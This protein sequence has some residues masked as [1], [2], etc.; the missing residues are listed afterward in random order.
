M[1]LIIATDLGLLRVYRVTRGGPGR[2]PH[3]ALLE[4]YRPAE[5]HQKLSEQVTDQAGRF[6]GGI[7][8]GGAVLSAGERHDLQQEQG[9]RLLREMAR[10]IDAHLDDSEVERACLAVSAPIR[11][12]LLAALQPRLRE[13]LNQV[14][15]LDLTHADPKELLAHFNVRIRG[16]TTPEA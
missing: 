5:A 12:Q 8:P 10:R 2:G 15:P 16:R 6:P 9:R 4:E 13:K 11:H 7:R 1:Q 14:L 3:L